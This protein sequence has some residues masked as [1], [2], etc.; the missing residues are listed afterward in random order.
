IMGAAV[1]HLAL[2]TQPN[3][4]IAASDLHTYSSLSTAKGQPIFIEDG[5]M[6]MASHLPGLGLEVDL[7]S[8][9]EPV[10][11]IAA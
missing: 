5:M 9:G 8:L 4:L 10:Q 11:V 7:E 6:G 2:T 1:T 3:R